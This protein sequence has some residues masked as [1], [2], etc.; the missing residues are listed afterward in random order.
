VLLMGESRPSRI[1][2]RCK[3]GAKIALPLDS[4]GRRARCPN[5]QR[6]F[7]VPDPGGADKAAPRP[8]AAGGVPSSESPPP[9]DGIEAIAADDDGVFK[10]APLTIPQPAAT[11]AP[12]KS[13]DA[14][15]ARTCPSCHKA[16]P[17]RAV[18]CVD[19]GIDLRTGRSL[20][21]SET[22]TLDDA[23]SRLDSVLSWL[24][25]IIWCGLY[26]FASEAFGTKKPFVV[27]GV[28][29]ATCV[30]SVAVMAAWFWNEDAASNLMLWSGREADHPALAAG[31]EEFVREDEYLDEEPTDEEVKQ[32]VAQILAEL[33]TGEFRAYQLLTHVFLHAD[34]IHLAGNMLF[35]LV[36]GGRVNALIG[37]VWTIVLYPL[38]GIV[39]AAAQMEASRD[40]P[41]M[42]MLG[43]S[44]AVM[45][46]AGMYLVFFPRHKVHMVFWFRW[47]LVAGFHLSMK[48]F[49]VAGF[50]VLLFYIAFDV[51]YTAL[52]IETGVAHWAHLGGFIA[53]I[54]FALMLMITRQVNARGGDLVSLVLGRRAWSIVGSPKGR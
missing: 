9:L 24:S 1:K 48:I 19:C 30:I 39:A 8:A 14:A 27:R 42:A 31:V 26:P 41:M 17:E 32:R 21:T 20:M 52:R 33:P 50:W 6:A 45:G 16:L 51:A 18:I 22:T 40:E 2:V 28:A 3:C 47:G 53:G 36:L 43:A 5:C 35:L 54:I 34:P 49:E 23:Y 13:A 29:L 46:L 38:L 44:G 37:N 11:P 7:R 10:L 12:Q 4:A 25:W 15:P